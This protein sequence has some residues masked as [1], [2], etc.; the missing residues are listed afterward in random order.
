[1]RV[2]NLVRILREK[3]HNFILVLPP[4]GGLYHWQ[5][6]KLGQQ[7]KIPWSLFFDLESLNRFVPVIEFDQYL[8]GTFSS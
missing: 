8:E 4:W 3:G 6:R 2:A 5:T 7:I 1:M